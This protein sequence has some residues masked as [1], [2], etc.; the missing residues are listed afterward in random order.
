[1]AKLTESFKEGAAWR[2]DGVRRAEAFVRAK[3][4]SG[5][6]RLLKRVMMFGSI[7]A[8]AILLVIGVFDPFHHRT[9]ALSVDALTI[10]G[11]NVTMGAAHR[12]GCRPDGRPRE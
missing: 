3:R 4:H 1:M 9:P 8:M 2:D 6:V 12:A 11:S 5:R 10:N 7:G